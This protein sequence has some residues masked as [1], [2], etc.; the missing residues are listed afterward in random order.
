MLSVM[1]SVWWAWLMAAHQPRAHEAPP[2]RKTC[3]F[4]EGTAAT[5]SP[6]R[7]RRSSSRICRKCRKFRD[8]PRR[9]SFDVENGASPGRS[10]LDGTSPS[11]GLVLQ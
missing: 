1:V 4:Q 8:G 7:P 9:H 5:P 11:A 10:P 2:S 3:T 6:Q